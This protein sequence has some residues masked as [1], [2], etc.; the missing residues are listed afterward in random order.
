[1]KM[2]P[3][4][5][6]LDY[7]CPAKGCEDELCAIC[8]GVGWVTQEQAEEY[9]EWRKRAVPPAQKSAQAALVENEIKAHLAAKSS[10]RGTSNDH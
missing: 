2:E 3:T 10:N 4:N 9:L 5:D 6:L 1:M 8:G 7:P